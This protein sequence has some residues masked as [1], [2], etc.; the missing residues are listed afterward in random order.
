MDIPTNG[1][2]G[3]EVEEVVEVDADAADVDDDG[4]KSG[5]ALYRCNCCVDAIYRRFDTK[6]IVVI[7]VGGG[8]NDVD[9]DQSD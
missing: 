3:V 8:G 6:F 7:A 5:W 4:I 9:V 2:D 1:D